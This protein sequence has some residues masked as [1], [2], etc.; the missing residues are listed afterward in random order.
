M[1]PTTPLLTLA[2]AAVPLA[3]RGIS[4]P[5]PMAPQ[6]AYLG[7]YVADGDADGAQVTR[8]MEASPAG[9]AGLRAGDRIVSFG[10][11]PVA[12]SEDL[13]ELVAARDAGERI[14]VVFLRGDT[15]RSYEIQ[16]GDKAALDAAGQVWE[17]T[18]PEGLGRLAPETPPEW[19]PEPQEA[20]PAEPP[21]AAHGERGIHGY[22]DADAAAEDRWRH[23][24]ELHSAHADRWSVELDDRLTE[25][26]RRMEDRWRDLSNEISA[27]QR[28]RVDVSFRERLER[29]R[30]DLDRDLEARTSQIDELRD[31]MRAAEAEGRER[32]H[33]W[34]EEAHERRAPRTELRWWG[35][36]SNGERILT[37]PHVVEIE[38]VEPGVPHAQ[39]IHPGQMG[40]RRGR[41]SGG[42]VEALRDE[43][44]ELRAEIQ[45]L[46][47]LLK[48]R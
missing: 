10:G 23:L 40:I 29:L 17:G 36:D 8:L 37:Q 22:A 7:I 21:H 35:Q 26:R 2:L 12:S 38:P 11:E 28:E 24:L 34:I 4:S 6:D 27:F 44:R 3:V 31:R 41:A 20:A 48:N 9:E 16:L 30:Q 42:D 43:V 33:R 13:V 47:E 19:V 18:L 25:L 14:E 15:Q 46:K 32:L 39:P 45:G 5:L 1:N